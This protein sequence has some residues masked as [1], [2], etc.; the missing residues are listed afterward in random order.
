MS[1]LSSRAPARDLVRRSLVAPLLGMTLALPGCALF[2]S[3]EEE[4]REEIVE[5]ALDQVGEDYEYGGADPWDGF[6]CSGLVFYSYGENG[7]KLPRSSREQ[8]KAGRHVNFSEAKPADL[9]FYN[10]AGAKAASGKKPPLA[11]HVAL[12]I[13][14]GK[15][16][17][18][19]V[20]DGEVEVIDV[21]K[22]YWRN[23]YLGARRI[24]RES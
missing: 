15:A 12:Y 19:P 11:L 17:H 22:M 9:L 20:T 7:I 23:R 2:Q 3:D 21:T 8:R 4:L 14:D 6:D 16:V 1:A 24:I 13:G 18:A 10:F 5:T